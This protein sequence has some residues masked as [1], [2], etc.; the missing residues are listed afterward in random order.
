MP[1]QTNV[2][3][4]ILLKTK[5]TILLVQYFHFFTTKIPRTKR[6]IITP[7]IIPM[8]AAVDKPPLSDPELAVLIVKSS[9][10]VG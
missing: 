2:S 10:E 6:R 1:T 4:T 3:F 7:A 9:V 5:H 8:V